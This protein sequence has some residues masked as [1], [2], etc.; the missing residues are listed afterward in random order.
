MGKGLE[1]GQT[2]RVKPE[3]GG[4]F[5]NLY[6][7]EPAWLLHMEQEEGSPG[8]QSQAINIQEEEAMVAAGLYPR[9]SIIHKHS[10]TPEKT[11]PFP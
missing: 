4:S 8:V 10:R 11:F 6:N 5:L 7:P 9:W 1:K 3:S 2:H